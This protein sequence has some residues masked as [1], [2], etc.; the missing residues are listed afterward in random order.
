[1]R[2]Y[3]ISPTA[4]GWKLTMYQDG[5]EVGGGVGGMDDFDFLVEQ[6]MSFCGE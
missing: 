1:M 5:E 6:A 4:S 3:E 2:S